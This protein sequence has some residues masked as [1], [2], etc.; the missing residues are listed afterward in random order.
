[1]DLRALSVVA[2][3]ILSLLGRSASVERSFST[4]RQICSDYQMAMK[5]ET[6]AA[7]AMI[8]VNWRVAQPLL[9][10]VLAT[11]RRGWTRITRQREER[12]AEQNDPW[13][14]DIS[15]EIGEDPGV[16]RRG[17]AGE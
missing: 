17:M 3:K 16:S 12:K 6:I 10:D 8:Q 1:V 2:I 4:A 9:R 11:G 15:G 5:Q 14:S 13:G 7:R